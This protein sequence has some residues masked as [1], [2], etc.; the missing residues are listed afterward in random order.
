M[1]DN[2]LELRILRKRFYSSRAQAKLR[3]QEWEISF[4]EYKNLWSNGTGFY[5]SGTKP[6]S[7]NMVRI[8]LTKGWHMNNVTII[9]RQYNAR[10]QLVQ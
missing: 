5:T 2:N 1:T 8:D 7:M 9:E 4:E 10:R 6:T 3:G